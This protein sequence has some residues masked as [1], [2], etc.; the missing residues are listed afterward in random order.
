[1][2][3]ETTIDSNRVVIKLNDGT[4]STGGIKTKNV[5]LTGIKKTAITEED[6][7]KILNIVQAY[8]AVVS[9]PVYQTVVTTAS[10][11]AEGA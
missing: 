2:A 6:K 8:R 1:M 5:N 10:I 11:I 4:T 7:Q 3:V 9:L